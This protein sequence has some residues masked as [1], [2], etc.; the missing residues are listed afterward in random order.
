M[1]PNYGRG[2][3]RVART[4]EELVPVRSAEW[5]P[6]DWRTNGLDKRG[7]GVLL[8]R[9]RQTASEFLR[10]P[11]VSI[12]LMHGATAGNDPFFGR[13]VQQFYTEATRRH[14]RALVV[15]QMS[16]GLALC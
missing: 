12:N 7:E 14:P 3:D 15:R 8:S 5:G 2:H 6:R 1:L 16:H 9:L 11:R 13:I 10:M 4:A